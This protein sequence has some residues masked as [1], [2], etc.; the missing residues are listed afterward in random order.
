MPAEEV[1]QTFVESLSIVKT[2]INVQRQMLEDNTAQLSVHQN[3]MLMCTHYLS[4]FVFI[5]SY[6][7]C[8]ALRY[9][10]RT[11]VFGLKKH[12]Y[13]ELCFANLIH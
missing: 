1:L 8:G 10:R 9:F 5:C 11:R 4:P 3:L 12:Y 7:Q 6:I 2:I 13:M